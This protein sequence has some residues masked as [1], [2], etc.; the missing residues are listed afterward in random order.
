[1]LDS[2]DPKIMLKAAVA[3]LDRTGF[4]AQQNININQTVRDEG[5]KAILK[6]I[7]ALADRLGVPVA[8]LLGSKPASPVVEGEFSEVSDG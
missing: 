7:E 4:G 2:E 5:S 8:G 6:R 3:V 1:M